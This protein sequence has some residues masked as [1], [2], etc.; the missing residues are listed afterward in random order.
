VGLRPKVASSFGVNVPQDHQATVSKIAVEQL[1]EIVI[2]GRD[3]DG[4][5]SFDL[6]C[7]AKGSV[8]KKRSKRETSEV[9]S[10]QASMTMS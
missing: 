5:A 4:G 10:C 2:N 6:L 7:H 1:V 8:R 9:V 3:A